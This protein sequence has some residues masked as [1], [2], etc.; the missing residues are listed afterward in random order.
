MNRRPYNSEKR[1]YLIEVTFTVS[2]QVKVNALNEGSASLKAAC[3]NYWDISFH[4]GHLIYLD[5]PIFETISKR[6]VEEI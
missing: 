2:A 4:G 1:K 5:E 3:S 6:D